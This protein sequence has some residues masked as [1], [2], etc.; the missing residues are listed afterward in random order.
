MDVEVLVADLSLPADVNRVAAALRADGELEVLVNNAGACRW[1]AFAERDLEEERAFVDLMVQAPLELTHAAVGGLIERGRGAIINVS[2]RSAL[3]PHP[4]LAAYSGAKAFLSAFTEA[5]AHD[6]EPA[7]VRCL[8]VCPGL[9][10]TELVALAGLPLD[11]LASMPTPGAVVAEAL[12]DFDAGER[13][14]VPGEARRDRWIRRSLPS[15]LLRK[16]AGVLRRL[17]RV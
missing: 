11:G 9:T 10:N 8:A 15:G 14:S 4:Q 12:R 16:A 7:G 6:L 3:T 17:A 2:S 13:I 1:G 5:I